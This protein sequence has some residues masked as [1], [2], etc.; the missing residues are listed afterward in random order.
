MT[1]AR[2]DITI[3]IPI[4]NG[5]NYLDEAIQSV[6]N[7]TCDKWK[8]LLADDQSTDKSRDII[9]KCLKDSRIS[10]LYHDRNYGLYG[11]LAKVVPHVNSE[12]IVIL[13]QD[14]R[15]KPT[16][17]EEMASVITRHPEVKAF[18][19]TEDL[20]NQEG[21]RLKQGLET[22][23]IEVIS[24]GRSPW[25]SIL[26]RGCIWTISGSLTH[27]SLLLTT[28][29]KADLPHCGDY[30][31]LLRA[32]RKETFIYYQQAL[33][34]LRIHELQASTSNLKLGR[35]IREYHSILRENL[36]T[37]P[38]AVTRSQVLGISLYRIKGMVIRMLSALSKGS[39]QHA[40]FLGWYILKLLALPFQYK[41]TGA[42][43]LL[44]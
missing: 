33:I 42:L 31:W 44:K 20:I 32:I 39:F 9:E 14:D 25:I 26:K 5:E 23:R 21:Q 29:F 19:G 15:L 8:L 3:I 13:M 7:Q 4:Y 1:E 43:H 24:P 37:N 18:W 11:G 35:D 27:K 34:E 2:P 40:T 10:K 36:F 16:Y 12:W 6:I 41:K 38:E 28:P 17:L 22:S 30:D